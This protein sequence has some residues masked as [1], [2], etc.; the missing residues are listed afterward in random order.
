[1]TRSD[2]HSIRSFFN[3]RF[4]NSL[5]LASSIRSTAVLEP[6]VD[7]G[8]ARYERLQLP[9]SFGVSSVVPTEATTPD[10]LLSDCDRTLYQ[11]KIAGR[12]RI[13]MS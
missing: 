12:D 4:E 10:Q 13:R 9:P 6:S 3:L 11:A 7:E 5:R 1:M 2:R 8:L